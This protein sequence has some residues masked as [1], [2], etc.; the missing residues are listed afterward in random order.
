[1]PT[2]SFNINILAAF[3]N[4][5]A[6]D[7]GDQSN[8]CHEIRK[9]DEPYQHSPASK[10]DQFNDSAGN[11][12]LLYLEKSAS[13]VVNSNIFLMSTAFYPSDYMSRMTFVRG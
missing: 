1:M 4:T 3:V 2:V 12:R 11:D 9:I 13:L 8:Y 5:F 6:G 7:L 10:S